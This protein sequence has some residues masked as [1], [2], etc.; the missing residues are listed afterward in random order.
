MWLFLPRVVHADGGV[1][2]IK[3]LMYKISF[4]IINPLIIFGFVLALLYFIWGVIEFL[5]S[6]DT[7]A[8]K[9]AEGRAHML[10]GV[11]GLVIMVSA[12][13]IMRLIGQTVGS[14]IPT[15]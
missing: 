15:P 10:Y 9:G 12:F 4:Y 6:R 5:R 1:L 14:T 13:A 11:I 7:N 3:Q 8:E 2:S